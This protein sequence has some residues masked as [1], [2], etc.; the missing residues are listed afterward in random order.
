M[1]GAPTYD[2][3]QRV[4][5]KGLPQISV[6]TIVRD[7]QNFIWIGTENGLARF[8]GRNFEFFN[9]VNTP[10]LGSNWIEGLFLDDIGDVWI[11]TRIGLVRYSNGEFSAIAS[12]LNGEPVQLIVLLESRPR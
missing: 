10:E 3:G 1:S 11:A 2:I 12:D 5:A 8:D 7:S 6:K 4:S 9:T